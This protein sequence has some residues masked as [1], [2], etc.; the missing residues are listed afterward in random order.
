MDVHKIVQTLMVVTIAL[1]VLGILWQLMNMDVMVS[2]LLSFPD[3]N[4]TLN[5]KLYTMANITQMWMNVHRIFTTVNIHVRILL[6]H[7]CVAAML[8]MS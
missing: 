5:V 2:T 6:D 7:F 8:D 4:N 3:V 1:V